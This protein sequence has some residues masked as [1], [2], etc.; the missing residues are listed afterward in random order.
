MRRSSLSSRR[1]FRQSLGE[2][3]RQ[4]GWTA[5]IG[6]VCGRSHALGRLGRGCRHLD[7]ALEDLAGGALGEVVEEPDD[8]GGLVGGDPFLD[9]GA[10]LLWGQLLAVVE[11]DG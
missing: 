3:Y 4:T 1:C 8:A 11:D 10:D 7:L 6:Q 5:R 9:V 2:G